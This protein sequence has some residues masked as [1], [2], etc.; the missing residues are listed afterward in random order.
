MAA[1]WFWP[2]ASECSSSVSG[3]LRPGAYVAGRHTEYG[4]TR[5]RNTGSVLNG[6]VSATPCPSSTDETYHR[7]EVPLTTGSSVVMRSASASH[8]TASEN[9]DTSPSARASACAWSDQKFRRA[10]SC[11]WVRKATL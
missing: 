2:S 1:N 6:A 11:S 5:P 8:G 10:F 7:V 4:C 9:S 3:N